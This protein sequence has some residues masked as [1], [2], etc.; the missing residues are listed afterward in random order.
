MTEGGDQRVHTPNRSH[1][2]VP[3]EKNKN[4]ASI[5]VTRVFYS[6]VTLDFK[7]EEFAFFYVS[8]FSSN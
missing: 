8:V 7:D 3:E 5:T 4:N 2:K 6:W 1:A